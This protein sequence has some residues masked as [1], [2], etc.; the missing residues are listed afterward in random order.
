MSEISISESHVVGGTNDLDR[1]VGLCDEISALVR[2]GL[3]LEESLL[4]MGR[5]RRGR[6]GRQL[7][8]M[9]ETLGTGKPLAEAVRNDS[10]FPPVFA[11]VIEAGI[12]SGNLS[13]A[14]DSV[15]ESVR[16]LRDTRL[17]LLRSSL[18]PLVLFTSLWLIFSF[19]VF[20]VVPKF[21]YF[22]ESYDQSFILFDFFQSIRMSEWGMPLFTFGVPALLWLV[23]LCWSYCS[24]RKNVIQSAGF[25]LMFRWMPWVGS[26]SVELQK[27]AFAKIL[28]M[29]LRSSIPLDKSILLAA[30][31]CNDRYWGKESIEA[32]RNRVVR[33]KSDA[34][35]TP[36]YPKS[37]LSPLI[38]WTLGISNQKMLLEGI[39]HYAK[40]A[41]TRADLLLSQCE[42]FLPA[43]LT[44]I[45]AALIGLCYFMTVLWPYVHILNFLTE[46]K[47]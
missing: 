24:A 30:R 15:S 37:V 34:D 3:P 17:F 22:Y 14:L 40:I 11:A 16:T 41:R 12:E 7:R 26:A 35:T 1:L 32:L 21:S 29:L 39:D 18:Y 36:A 33:G 2:T 38:E 44:L 19:L 4:L 43:I 31:T 9:A 10:S 23:Y 13:G 8:E 45:L 47:L 28:A 20:A 5:A 25:S 42:M 6:I 46:P 27:V